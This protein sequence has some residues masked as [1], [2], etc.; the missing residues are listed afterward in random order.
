MTSQ[1]TSIFHITNIIYFD[2]ETGRVKVGEVEVSQGVGGRV[3]QYQSSAVS[4]VAQTQ[5]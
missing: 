4:P 1:Y 3:R 2:I 5:H